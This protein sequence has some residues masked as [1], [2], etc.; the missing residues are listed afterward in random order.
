MILAFQYISDECQA[1]N[2]ALQLWLNRSFV[3]RRHAFSAYSFLSS[4]NLLNHNQVNISLS[5]QSTN[6]LKSVAMR[7]ECQSNIING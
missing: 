4:V 1:L 2:K 3:R 6:L 5:L 7:G